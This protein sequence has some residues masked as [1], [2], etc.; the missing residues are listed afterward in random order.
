MPPIADRGAAVPSRARLW[1][2][3]GGIAFAIRIAAALVTGGLWRPELFEYDSL[4]RALLAG[5]GFTY[6]HLNIVYY[7]FAAPLYSWIS[8]ALYWLTGGSAAGIMLLQM[9]VGS[10]LAVVVAAMSDYL[11]ESRLAG[12]AAGLLVACHPGLV[13]YS[14]FKAH[15]LTYDALFFTL[16][17]WQCF[18]LHQRSTLGRAIVLG[19]I[20]GVGALSRATM[21]VF[22]PTGALWLLAVSPRAERRE[23]VVRMFVAGLCAAAI[24]LPWTIRNTRLLHHFVA[25]QTTDSELLWRGNNPFATGNSYI[26]AGHIVLDT[27]PAEAQHELRSQPD[28]VAQSRWFRARAMAYIETHPGTFVRLTLQK[29]FQ[30][31]WLSPQTGLLYPKPWLLLYQAYYVAVLLLAGIGVASLIRSGSAA[32]R[33]ALLLMLFLLVLSGLQSFYYVEGRHR[34]A[35]EPMVLAMSGGGVAALTARGCARSVRV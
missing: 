20:V 19:L 1:W 4:A 10:G 8:A 24:V 5:R 32:W 14:S 2:A 30:F 35:V 33:E 29:F 28:E 7:A 12:L 22:F 13:L 16:V 18:R 25:M 34:W 3:I 11:F 31:W 6:T 9:V 15:P 23:A 21:L 26:E 17:L 27:L